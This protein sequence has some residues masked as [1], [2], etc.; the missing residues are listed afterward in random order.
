MNVGLSW[1]SRVGPHLQ[2]NR[3]QFDA[4]MPLM[5]PYPLVA[6]GSRE[7]APYWRTL[8]W[9]QAPGALLLGEAGGTMT[10]LDGAP[11]RAARR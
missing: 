9:D 11:Y 4:K 6:T 1:S 10:Y 7:F 3:R 8:V 2:P 5:M